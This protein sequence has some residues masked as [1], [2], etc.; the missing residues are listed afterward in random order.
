[1]CLGSL[2]RTRAGAR[3]TR[4]RRPECSTRT[5]SSHPASRRRRC[6]LSSASRTG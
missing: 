4:R 1:V 3:R 2:R 5:P 6:G